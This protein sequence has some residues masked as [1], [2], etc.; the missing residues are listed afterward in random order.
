M[1]WRKIKDDILTTSNGEYSK[2]VLKMLFR[3][4]RIFALLVL[5]VFY[6]TGNEPVV[7]IG[8]VTTFLSVEVIQLARIKIKKVEKDED[9]EDL[10]GGEGNV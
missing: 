7:L 3:D 4:F 1:K 8:A 6:K 5:V 9:K 2:K 10:S